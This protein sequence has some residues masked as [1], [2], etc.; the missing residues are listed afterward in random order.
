MG[1]VTINLVVIILSFSFLCNYSIASGGDLG[2]TSGANGSE[3]N[4]WLIQDFDDFNAFCSD[5]TKWASNQYTRLETDLDLDPSL[6]GRQTYTQAPIAGDTDSSNYSHDGEAYVGNFQGSSHAISNLTVDGAYYCG[7]FGYISSGGSVSNLRLEHVSVNGTGM[8]V[9]GLCGRC[10]GSINT[11]SIKGDVTGEDSNVGGLCGFILGSEIISCYVTG[12]VTGNGKVG[13]LC[14]YVYNGSISESYSSGVVNGVYAVGGL[15]GFN[16]GSEIISCYVTGTVSG[17]SREVGGL[18]GWNSGSMTECY[19][20]GNIT[21]EDRY[22]GGLCGKSSGIIASC[23]AS[24]NIVG[25][26]DSVGGLCGYN[27]EG[28][29]NNS[30]AV[31]GGI[32]YSYVGGLCGTNYGSIINCYASGSVTGDFCVRGLCGYNA[33]SS[34]EIANCFWDIDTSG[35]SDGYYNFSNSP[36][37]ITNVQ[38]L[39]TIEMQIQSTFTSS[40]WDFITETSNGIED[41]WY[42]DGY[43]VLSWQSDLVDVTVPKIVGININQAEI[44]IENSGLFI[45]DILYEYNTTIP[46]NS[47]ISQSL[48]SGTVVAVNSHVDI[49]ISLGPALIGSGT[50]DNPYIISSYNDFQEFINDPYYWAE[51]VYTC[52]IADI[53]LAPNLPGRE[54]Y[55]NAL[56]APYTGYSSPSFNGNLNGNGFSIEGLTI[57]GDSRSYVGLFGTI[58]SAEIKN[59]GVKSC[60]ISGYDYVG[61]LV[62]YIGYPGIITNCFSTGSITGNAKVGGLIGGGSDGSRVVNCYSQGI[63]TGGNGDV[64]GLV[65]F[66]FGN[67]TSCYSTGAVTGDNNI[68]GLV[69][70]LESGTTTNSYSNSSVTGINA[71][72]GGLVGC[73]Y[74]NI[75]N[76]YSTGNVEGSENVGGLVGDNSFGDITNCYSIGSVTGNAQVGGLVGFELYQVLITNSYFLENA[77][78]DNS[79]GMSLSDEAMRLQSS[80]VGWDFVGEV[81]NGIDD[82]W[83]MDMYPAFCWE[84]VYEDGSEEHP[85]LIENYS[86]FQIFISDPNFWSE[87]VHAILMDNIDLDP[88]LEGREIYYKAPIAPDTGIATSSYEGLAYSGNFDG[89]NC[90]ISNLTITGNHYCGLF[91]KIDGGEVSNLTI[92]NSNVTSSGRDSSLL[93]GV[94]AGQIINCTSNGVLYGNS[95]N[96]GGNICLGGLVGSNLGS[97]TES[98]SEI[99]LSVRNTSNCIGGLAGYSSGNIQNCNSSGTIDGVTSQVGG[100]V[101]RADIGMIKGCVSLCEIISGSGEAGGLVGWNRGQIECSASSGDVKITKYSY[102]AGGFVGSNDGVIKSSYCEGN[103]DGYYHS[104]GLVGD[105]GGAVDNCYSASNVYGYSSVGGLAGVSSGDFMACYSIG[106]VTG[107]YGLGAIVGEYES[108]NIRSCFWET[109]SCEIDTPSGNSNE[110]KGA[111]GL[112]LEEMQSESTFIEYCWDFTGEDT[113]GK[114]DVWYMDDYPRL[115]DKIAS[116]EV[117]DLGGGDGSFESPYLIENFFDFI[118]FCSDGSYWDDYVELKSDIDL[119]PILNWRE[120]YSQYLIGYENSSRYSGVFNGNGHVIRDLTMRGGAYQCLFATASSTAHISNLGLENIDIKGGGIAVGL[121]GELY[122]GIIEDCYVTGNIE[123]GYNP[124]YVAGLC[125]GNEKGTITGC[126]ADCNIISGELSNFVGVLCGATDEGTVINCYSKGSIDCGLNSIGCGG[127]TGGLYYGYIKYCYSTVEIKNYGGGFIGNQ[128]YDFDIQHCYWDVDASGVGEDGDDVYGAL[129]RTTEWLQNVDNYLDDGW[130]F[131]GEIVNGELD[132]WHMQDYPVLA[133]QVDLPEGVIGDLNGDD[134]VNLVDFAVLSLYWLDTCD[135]DNEWCHGADL[136]SSSDI[137]ILD[138]YLFAECWLKI[139][140]DLNDDDTVDL[141]DFAILSASWMENYN[142]NDLAAMFRYWLW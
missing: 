94:N 6:P 23:Y 42:M 44:I 82:Y 48:I 81:N 66:S 27:N 138:L 103:I 76:G 140:I 62:G 97:I 139:E 2:A 38:G 1:K 21:G 78:P 49:V 5:T 16:S 53:D 60:D 79:L 123:V 88:T 98:S 45:G 122:G 4:P 77:G 107:S 124:Y 59:L 3:S 109:N 101:G 37:V 75:V 25:S 85:W 47:V 30:Y 15:C 56:I 83:R 9:G 132:F 108:G 128:I 126:Y 41:V 125:G 19:A 92:S 26:D 102:N 135:D 54:V 137:D 61:G 80:F 105:N 50:I 91:G 69:G 34:A 133:W 46:E 11:C 111:L 36:G 142:V 51:G 74:G 28:T 73:N 24:G 95:S 115:N 121:C 64:G 58:G 13:G 89:N 110:I 7:L 32:G 29:I 100:L 130:D 63:V 134:I 35:Q 40:G 22:V 17:S 131:T 68:G 99:D 93:A 113:N 67:I 33:S 72:A 20:T 117:G 104:G 136:D 8:N 57:N 14:G 141:E 87:G 65:G 114:D 119:N 96:V 127:F 118:E 112:S 71:N 12:T 106:A 39:A 55:T 70:M 86:E 43:P 52:L 129:G 84:E 120:T 18:C 31:G 10:H 90:T 116:I